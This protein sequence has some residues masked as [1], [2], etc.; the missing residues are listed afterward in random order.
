MLAT[1][2]VCIHAQLSV[3]ETLVRDV[4]NLERLGVAVVTQLLVDMVDT[5]SGNMA[6]SSMYIIMDELNI[7]CPSLLVCVYVTRF[8]MVIPNVSVK[9]ILD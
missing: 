9:C 4:A 7:M 6:V 3:I 1:L 2:S 8:T 5:S